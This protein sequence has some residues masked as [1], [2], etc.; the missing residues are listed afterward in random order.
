[1][2]NNLVCCFSQLL[3]FL[4]IQNVVLD[5]IVRNLFFYVTEYCAFN[6][7]QVRGIDFHD[8]I[9]GCHVIMH[10]TLPCLFLFC[11]W[12]RER[13]TTSGYFSVDPALKVNS[14]ETIPLECV[15]LQTVLSKSLGPL[16]EWSD[17]LRVSTQ[18]VQW[19]L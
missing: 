4:R 11:F 14:S 1:M 17:R 13:R 3:L 8:R 6:I 18:Y 2:I 7:S 19:I 5:T 16:E 10:Q 12:F 15:S 9:F